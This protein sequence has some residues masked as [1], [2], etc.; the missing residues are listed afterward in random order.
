MITYFTPVSVPSWRERTLSPER[1]LRLF[2]KFAEYS[3]LL[4]SIAFCLS[5]PFPLLLGS[6]TAGYP[7]GIKL[8]RERERWCQNIFST[9]IKHWY[10]NIVRR[11]KAQEFFLPTC[12]SARL[13][14]RI[15]P[16]L[17]LPCEQEVVGMGW[18]RPRQDC[19]LTFLWINMSQF[20]ACHWLILQVW[21]WWF[22]QFYYV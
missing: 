13:S 16:V 20:V 4:L 9:L 14:F 12:I 8:R 19:R 11:V 21:K 18:G 1:I 17:K 15:Q 3:I 6:T 5:K 10:L 22:S 7:V 2:S